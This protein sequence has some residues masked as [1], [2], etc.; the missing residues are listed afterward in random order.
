MVIGKYLFYLGKP[1]QQYIQHNRDLYCRVLFCL[2]RKI[3]SSPVK[4][5]ILGG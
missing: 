4:G 1:Y 2:W 5:Q 3:N